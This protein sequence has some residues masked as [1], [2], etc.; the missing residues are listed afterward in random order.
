VFTGLVKI[1][2]AVISASL[3]AG[4]RIAAEVEQ[5]PGA[6]VFIISCKPA[7]NEPMIRWL[8]EFALALKSSLRSGFLRKLW[9]YGREKR[10][11]FLDYPLEHSASVALLSSLECDVGLHAAN[12]IYREPTIGAFRLGILNAHIGILPSYRGRSVAQW[13]TLLGDPTGI[14]V[15]FIDSGIDTGSRIVLRELVPARAC[16]NVKALRRKLFACDAHLYRKAL[17]AVTSAGFPYER[18]D[19]SLGKRHYVMSKM[20]NEVVNDILAERGSEKGF[21]KAPETRS[22]SS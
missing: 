18:N 15:F 13:S 2:I 19:V 20:F 4:M 7:A 6:V 1:R 3:A 10:L 16:K 12:V 5:I 22:S 8:R 11:I 9:S 21:F 17:E 14:T